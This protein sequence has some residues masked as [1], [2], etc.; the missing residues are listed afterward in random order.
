MMK[1][2]KVIVFKTYAGT[3]GKRLAAVA[4][5]SDKATPEMYFKYMG[6]VDRIESYTVSPVMPLPFALDYSNRLQKQ[7]GVGT[8]R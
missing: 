4:T 3:N 8:A 7:M 5:I 6:L 2:A 1:M